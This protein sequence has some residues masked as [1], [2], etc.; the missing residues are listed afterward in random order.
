MKN[1]L[2][3]KIKKHNL[4]SEVI[5][6]IF[7]SVLLI[8]GIISDISSKEIFFGI[9]DSKNLDSICLALIQIEATMTAVLIAV[10][11]LLSSFSTKSF[12]GFS[13]SSYVLDLKPKIFNFGFVLLFELFL[14]FMVVLGQIVQYYNVIVTCCSISI[15]LIIV[16][17]RNVYCVFVNANKIYKEIYENFELLIKNKKFDYQNF[18]IDWKQSIKN[19]NGQSH[20][21][22]TQYRES[23]TLLLKEVE[24]S[25]KYEDE[26]KVKIFRELFNEVVDFLL[27]SEQL[28]SRKRGVRFVID[29]YRGRWYDFVNKDKGKNDFIITDIFS[30]DVWNDWWNALCSSDDDFIEKRCNFIELFSLI[31]NNDILIQKNANQTLNLETKIYK[32]KTMSLDS[33]YFLSSKIGELLNKYIKTANINSSFWKQLILPIEMNAIASSFDKH[34]LSELEHIKQIDNELIESLEIDENSDLRKSVDNIIKSLKK[35]NDYKI[36]ISFVNFYTFKSFLLS[37][38]IGL[39]ESV[40]FSNNNIFSVELQKINRPDDTDE[41]DYLELEFLLIVCFMLYVV[42]SSTNSKQN[43]ELS[44]KIIKLLI[45]S[46]DEITKNLKKIAKDHAFLEKIDSYFKQSFV[47]H[48][49]NHTPSDCLSLDKTELYLFA[50][51]FFVYLIYFTSDYYK[52]YDF[53]QIFGTL[54][55]HKILTEDLNYADNSNFKS[56][57]SMVEIISKCLDDSLYKVRSLEVFENFKKLALESKSSTFVLNSKEDINDF[58]LYK[59]SKN[60]LNSL[61]I[62]YEFCNLS[63]NVKNDE[64][65]VFVIF[66]N[67]YKSEK[68]LFK[69]EFSI[70]FGENVHSLSSAFADFEELEYVDLH[71]ESN[72]TDMNSMFRNAKNIIYIG[73]VSSNFD[74]SNVTNMSSMF[75]GATSFNQEIGNWDTSNV[76]NMSGMFEGAASFDQPIG[77]WDTSRVTDMS[78]MFQEALSFNQPIGNWDTSHVT[79]MIGMFR[80][81]TSFNQSLDNWDISNVEDKYSMFYKAKSFSQPVESWNWPNVE[82]MFKKPRYLKSRFR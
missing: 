32:N 25:E 1:N 40:F 13:L 7:L 41:N 54:E 73:D 11:A 70:S 2:K 31:F 82:E 35:D 67:K 23:L 42:Y 26:K 64:S 12:L 51:S 79:D 20:E 5:T 74:T 61:K 59:M 68:R 8:T 66:R 14:F 28:I 9:V 36:F 19:I 6:V 80:V 48:S 65:N 60:L 16:V 15:I 49:L 69:F 43:E 29:I 57:K 52:D 33:I 58:L 75:R 22:Y 10:I 24:Q 55:H 46:K 37:G 77:N 34:N 38:N 47:V 72:I 27:R 18:I 3:Q 45:N 71:I 39:I 76:T 44:Q 50:E 30:T 21:E 4:S 81:A 53:S 56:I 78:R 17:T 63:D 62:N